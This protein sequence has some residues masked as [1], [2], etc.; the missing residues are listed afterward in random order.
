M[1]MIIIGVVLFPASTTCVPPRSAHDQTLWPIIR[2]NGPYDV[3]MV[4]AVHLFER[5]VVDVLNIAALELMWTIRNIE[6][7]RPQVLF[8]DYG[9]VRNRGTEGRIDPTVFEAV[10]FFREKN[11]LVE[12]RGFGFFYGQED[13]TTVVP[14]DSVGDH[15]VLGRYRAE[16]QRGYSKGME[17]WASGWEAVVCELNVEGLSDKTVDESEEERGITLSTKLKQ[18]RMEHTLRGRRI[19]FV[20]FP[21]TVGPFFN[22]DFSGGA[23][24][25]LEAP[26]RPLRVDQPELLLW[27]DLGELDPER[28]RRARTLGYDY[29][30]RLKNGGGDHAEQSFSELLASFDVELRNLELHSVAPNGEIRRFG[31]GVNFGQMS[32]F[33]ERFLPTRTSVVELE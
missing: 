33:L 31:R 28:V 26:L 29:I 9:N 6:R 27:L 19:P 13:N 10:E 4:A 16:L 21:E 32:H 18:I 22:L 17:N 5:V 3:Y 25:N 14:A 1:K 15:A 2:Q 12:C 24:D 8:P 11:V 23:A 30:F 7:K 20:L